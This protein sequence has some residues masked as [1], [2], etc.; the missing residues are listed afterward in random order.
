MLLNYLNQ[1]QQ[2][3]CHRNFQA[4]LGNKPHSLSAFESEFSESGAKSNTILRSGK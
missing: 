1:Q 2:Q 4:F 3:G